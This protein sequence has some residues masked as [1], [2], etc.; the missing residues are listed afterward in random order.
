MAAIQIAWGQWLRKGI[1]ATAAIPVNKRDVASCIAADSVFSQMPL[2][3]AEQF[4]AAFI[5]TERGSHLLYTKPWVKT[6]S[7]GQ[8]GGIDS[9]LGSGFS[10]ATAVSQG[11]RNFISRRDLGLLLPSNSNYKSFNWVTWNY[12]WKKSRASANRNKNKRFT[13]GNHLG[14]DYLLAHTNGTFAFLEAKGICDAV[15]PT[16]PLFAKYKTQSMN[17]VL[18]IIG[19]R[20]FNSQTTR[21]LL[22]YVHLPANGVSPMPVEVRWFNSLDSVSREPD[23]LGL[24]QKLTQLCIAMTQLLRQ[25][26]N[27]QYSEEVY[28]EYGVLF[29]GQG[30]SQGLYV[31]YEA[32]ELLGRTRAF[33]ALQVNEQVFMH[34]NAAKDE[35]DAL[36]SALASIRHKGVESFS[37]EF[38]ESALP[39]FD[40]WNGSYAVNVTHAD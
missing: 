24:G 38:R 31:T 15:M 17:A 10:L 30:T 16:P 37:R 6:I 20:Q 2:H 11:Y 13:T 4:C 22:S 9:I 19:P 1:I 40:Y 18:G 34:S 8:R 29:H 36:Y 23:A 33:L 21:F 14:P 7:P 12:R 28:L 39:I 27:A 26:I 3:A 35:V 25:I 32:Q 5:N